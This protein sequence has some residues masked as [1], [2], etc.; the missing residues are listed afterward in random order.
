MNLEMSLRIRELR[1]KQGLTMKELAEKVGVTEQAISQY[2]RNIRKPNTETLNKIASALN[3]SSKDL[4]VMPADRYFGVATG[5]ARDIKELSE[6]NESEMSWEDIEGFTVAEFL[7]IADFSTQ[8][9]NKIIRNRICR[10]EL[11]I[12]A[13]IFAKV[14]F[15]K[16]NAIM[17]IPNN[18]LKESLQNNE[19]A[20][21]E[22]LLNNKI[23]K[24]NEYN[25]RL[26]SLRSSIY[27]QEYK[28]KELQ[29]SIEKELQNLKN[30]FTEEDKK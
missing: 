30:N 25:K 5:I 8:F 14:E 19:E 23:A 13:D 4:I 3:V 26:S 2:E 29:L 16:G 27:S 17:E 21:A 11:G 9:I 28:V 6:K 7:E 12:K 1:Q 15:V 18:S 10:N 20:N 24:L 22:E